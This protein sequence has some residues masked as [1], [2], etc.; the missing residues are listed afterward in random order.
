MADPTFY[1]HAVTGVERRDTHISAVFLTGS[2]VY[3][4]KKPLALGFLDFR[5]LE[6]RRTACLR[7]VE[8][9]RRLSHDV[10]R[11][12]VPIHRGPDGKISLSPG[13]R[14]VEYAVTMRQLPEA[15]NLR[16][17][18]ETGRAGHECMVEIGLRL[19]RFYDESE[20]SSAVDAYGS[21]DAVAYNMEENFRQLGPWV[22]TVLAG[23][24]WP[25]LCEANRA[26]LVDHKALFQ[27]RI[28]NGRIRDGHGD[29]RADHVYF[30]GGLQI[31][32]C[33]EFNDR[34]RYGDAAVDL[35]FLVMDMAALGHGALGY[36]LLAA[37]AAAAADP[38]VF[39]L[40]DFYVVYRALVR[41]KVSCMRL[42][43]ADADERAVL[44]TEIGRYMDL[45][46]RHTLMFARPTLWV[47]CGLPASGKSSLAARLGEAMG[48]R[49][50]SSDRVRKTMAPGSGVSPYGKGTYSDQRRNRVYGRLLAL[51][52]DEL[53]SGRSVILDATYGRRHWRD[54]VRQLASDM[55]AGL[56]FA[57]C[58][59]PLETLRRRLA[60]RDRSPGLSDARLGHLSRLS[61]EF[62]ALT[63]IPQAMRVSVDTDGP[64][65]N[66]VTALL[67]T[68]WALREL[69]IAGRS[70]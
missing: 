51:A 16:T 3:K 21:P 39:A 44:L 17:L 5:R 57:E 12:V 13:G 24:P 35:A 59:S 45:A 19:A 40:I 20:R 50:F 32:D 63:D 23:W 52:Q 62:E 36:T 15:S 34:F 68:A 37:Y 49:V 28:A 9:N 14:V 18:L 10:Y 61:A 43:A 46:Y 4:L 48:I 54:G 56:I 55:D 42:S 8:L 67:K 70:S 25:F 33:I 11:E 47:C 31:I 64:R 6:D 7:E 38:G 60:R 53:R 26:F 41:V 27:G 66:T 22:D 58:V 30:D 65:E 69:Q 2:I 29:L 1:P